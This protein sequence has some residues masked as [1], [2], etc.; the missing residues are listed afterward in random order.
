MKKKVISFVIASLIIGVTVLIKS[1][2]VKVKAEE[3][4]V[5]SGVIDQSIEELTDIFGPETINTDIPEQ[6]VQPLNQ[7]EYDDLIRS[8]P[9]GAELVDDVEVLPGVVK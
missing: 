1:E 6:R 2:I 3:S 4:E 7:A 5:K 8:L 9:E